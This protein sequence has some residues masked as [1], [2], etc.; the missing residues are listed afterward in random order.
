VGIALAVGFIAALG[1]FFATAN[2]HMTQQALQGAS[3]DW[4]VQLAPGFSQAAATQVV[5]AEPGVLGSRVVAYGNVLDLS[6]VCGG[7]RQ[8]AGSGRILGIAPGYS[9][10]FPN[11]IRYLIG[12]KNGTLIAQQGASNLSATV[13]SRITLRLPGGR[14][15]R[16]RVDGI[17]D[18]PQA[19]S[20]F[21]TVGAPPGYAPQAPPDN[22]V[23]VPLGVWN[24]LHSGAVPP[25]TTAIQLH[26]QLSSA[27]PTNPSSAYAQV[28]ERAHHLEAQFAGGA[29]LGDN[30]AVALDTARKDALYAQL[31]FLF[32]GVPGAIVALLLAG[33]LG[34]SGGTRRRREQAL[35]RL[36]GATAK[37]VLRL[38]VVE[39]LLVGVVGALAGWGIALLAA[40]VSFRASHLRA[41][42]AGARSWLVIAMLLGVVAA[43]AAVAVPAWRDLRTMSVT[44][45]RA[46]VS[47]PQRPLWARLYLDVAALA[48]AA[49]V[50]YRSA[51]NNFQIVLAPEGVTA[52]SVDYNVFLA[53]LLLWIGGALL[54]WRIATGV[55]T[56]GTR[57]IAAGVRPLAGPLASV[58]AASMRRQRQLLARGLVII[59]VTTSFA[60]STAVFNETFTAQSVVDARLT[61]GADV[62]A[63]S[64]GTSPLPP[65]LAAT[66]PSLPGVAGFTSL[67]HRFAYVGTDLQ[68]LFGI[69]AS[70]FTSATQISDAFFA[71]VT[72]KDALH[73]LAVQRNAILVSAET[74]LSYGLK[75]GS[76]IVLRLQFARDH[77]YHAVPFVF[78][79]VVRE[80][81]TAPHD[82]FFIANA[83][84][85]AEMTGDASRQ[86]ILARA[87]GRPSSVAG[88]IRRLV[89]ASSG[90]V[91]TSIDQ[92]LSNVTSG[93]T[94]V[95]LSGLTG[96]ELALA[97][98]L[99]AAASGMVL[100]LG[101]SERRRTFAIAAGLGA[102]GRDLASFVWSEVVFVLAG[103]MLTGALVGVVLAEVLVKM[104]T[105]VFDPPPTGLSIPVVYLLG[106]LGVTAA[107]G[108]AAAVGSIRST[109]RPAMEILRDL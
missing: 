28:V 89:P 5:A 59:S 29:V 84:Y 80:F 40:Q 96:L 43:L 42:A 78:I 57:A 90:V 75:P 25:G 87:S 105:G 4:Q 15:A 8:D 1:S 81:P 19:N 56:T 74:A 36:R 31:L 64:T 95:D 13:G 12:A 11:E 91:V 37:R 34:A 61:N 86:T 66:V 70:S 63:T 30:V 44:S 62:A 73:R 10:K 65:G 3:V 23:L 58:V 45:A 60:V 47:T 71:G 20:M 26:V 88:E 33:V 32:L 14:V 85:V 101:L 35:L 77:R 49:F 55:L 67:Q 93:L 76:S 39:G 97:F 107:S 27:L 106:L 7:S 50:Y 48:L 46:T 82:S 24:S 51:G 2:A 69:D 38:A 52:T 100:A 41:D 54:A 18:L 92:Q 99:A 6:C 21:Q 109:R 53:P 22:V 98:L 102:R 108:V 104:L 83:P 68:D 79:G 72:A 103:G 16:L 94:T 17:I 9:S